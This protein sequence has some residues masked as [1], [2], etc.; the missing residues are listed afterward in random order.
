MATLNLLVSSYLPDSSGAPD[1]GEKVVEEGEEDQENGRE[2]EEESESHK[3][4]EE[5]E[6]KG[7]EKGLVEV[8][9]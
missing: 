6:G 3:K 4:G 7:K 1:E 5:L 8:E 2:E 9:A